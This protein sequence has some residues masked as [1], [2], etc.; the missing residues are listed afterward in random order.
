M[1]ETIPLRDADDV[2][3][4][5][6]D[7]ICRRLRDELATMAGTRLLITGGAGFLG[8]YFVH[9]I[10]HHN[11]NVS[12]AEQI[13]LTVFD[14]YVRGVPGWTKQLD[15]QHGIRFLAYDLAAPLPAGIGDFE[16]VIHAASIASP[17][18]YRQ[19]PIE[20]MDSNVN[21]LRAL[22]DHF[23]RQQ[24]DG[25]Q[26]GGFLFMSSS[27]IYGDP[28][29]ECIPTPEDYRGFVSCTGP[30]ACYDEAKRYGETLCVNFA[31]QY[32]LPVRA[33]RPFNNYGPGLK[34]TDRRVLPDFARDVFAGTDITILSDGTPMRTFCYV[35]DA[36]VGYYKALVGGGVGEAYNIGTEAPEISMAD[37][38]QRMADIASDLFGYRGSVVLGRTSDPDYLR[39]NPNRRCPDLSKARSELGYEPVV[40]LDEGLRRMLIWYAANCGG[41]DA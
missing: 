7:S 5:D 39:D 19:R 35:A 18:Y 27:E 20:T 24:I 32:G 41:D 36:V 13:S 25:K 2:V 9:A 31:Q 17:N 16:Y 29:P 38:A 8:Y 15:R 30:R 26:V 11:R 23:H 37:L 34:I 10:H 33:A 3:A 14:N 40:T 22:L 1:A 21:G 12:E 4:T 28:A 6:V